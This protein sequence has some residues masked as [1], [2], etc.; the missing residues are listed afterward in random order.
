MHKIIYIV[1]M[2]LAPSIG[3]AA[4]SREACAM[5]LGSSQFMEV[6]QSAVDACVT[7]SEQKDKEESANRQKLINSRIAS[8]SKKVFLQNFSIG[9][10]DSLGGVRVDAIISNPNKTSA[11]KYLQI[12]ATPF[13]A[14]GDKVRSDINGVSTT[15]LLFTGPLKFEAEDFEES[16]SRVWYSPSITCIHVERIV[17][18]FMNGRVMTMAGKTLNDALGGKIAKDCRAKE[19]G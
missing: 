19:A 7:E 13:N 15:D 1:L 6:D 12:K 18:E 11:I 4:L 8:K 5:T 10:M 2:A 14:V 3:N 9:Y 16:W 17:V